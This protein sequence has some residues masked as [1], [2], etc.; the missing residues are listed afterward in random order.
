[1]P[2]PRTGA[3]IFQKISSLLVEWNIEDKMFQFT[4]RNAFSNE[5][6]IELLES[7]LIY[8]KE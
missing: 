1:M 2:P 4:L 6:F 7:H 3:A 8:K 5:N